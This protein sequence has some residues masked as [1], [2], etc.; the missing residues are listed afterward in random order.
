MPTILQFRRGTAAQNANYAGSAGEVTV[1]TTNATLRVHDGATNGGSVMA[2]SA[3]LA[4]GN[5][6]TNIVT[7]GNVGGTYFNGTSTTAQYADLAERYQAD[8][9]YPPGMVMSF[10]GTAEVTVSTTAHDPAVAGIVSTDPAYLMNSGLN[11]V[12]TVAI[13]LTGRVPCMVKGPVEK[14]TVLVTSDVP[15]VA[16]AIDNNSF[17][18]GV[19][20]GKSMDVVAEG[21]TK[22]IEVAVG[23]F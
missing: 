23:R 8:A 19:V 6:S 16:Q 14:G 22:L 9:N 3:Y 13:A 20:L 2:S 7:T 18:P 17:V 5:W 4:S 15:G 12:H 11:G 1:D 10:G 21:D